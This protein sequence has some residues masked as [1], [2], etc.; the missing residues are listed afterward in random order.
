MRE[1]I[2]T[3][4]PRHIQ[5]RRPSPQSVSP[6]LSLSTRPRT[7]AIP[8]AVRAL[9]EWATFIRAGL[10]LSLAAGANPLAPLPKHST[11]MAP[12]DVERVRRR[13]AETFFGGFPI[14]QARH[15][16]HSARQ[17]LTC[18][19]LHTTLRFVD[20]ALERFAG[21]VAEAL[22]LVNNPETVSSSTTSD[23]LL[24]RAFDSAVGILDQSTRLIEQMLSAVDT[25]LLGQ[26]AGPRALHDLR[27]ALAARFRLAAADMHRAAASVGGHAILSPWEL[28]A[29]AYFRVHLHLF[30]A[31]DRNKDKLPGWNSGS[32][33]RRSSSRLSFV[34][35]GGGKEEG[36][37]PGR[38]AS[39]NRND[40]D[41]EM[42]DGSAEDRENLQTPTFDNS[43][44]DPFAVALAAAGANGGGIE[45]HGRQSSARL[46]RG[47]LRPPIDTG[48][49]R[50]KVASEGSRMLQQFPDGTL[51]AEV[52][53]SVP[54]ELLVD[55][56]LSFRGVC[57][58]LSRL[59]LLR[60][61]EPVYSDLVLDTVRDH[62]RS[63]C[64]GS[65]EEEELL[66][67]MVS[68]AKDVAAPWIGE[69]IGASLAPP[70]PE[71]LALKRE[72]AQWKNRI[73]F[74][75]ARE[76]A[77]L[78]ISEIFN[79]VV[80]FPNSLPAL[81]DLRRAMGHV[82]AVPLLV[83]TLN[84][85]IH[86]RLLHQGA[87]TK[88]ILQWYINA[89]KAMRCLDPR[90][91]VLARCG[92]GIRRYLRSRE[93]TVRCIIT[94]ILDDVEGE[95]FVA[96]EGASQMAMDEDEEEGGMGPNDEVVT[97]WADPNWAPA[98][99]EAD[100]AMLAESKHAADIMATLVSIYDTKEVFIREFQTLLADRLLGIRNYDTEREVRNLEML[101]LRFGE[102]SLSACEVMLKDLADSKRLD[103]AIQ[104]SNLRQPGLVGN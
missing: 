25:N 10:A 17:L 18:S 21:D 90:G 97:D 84:N 79:M 76:F 39:M 5:V 46:S 6:P 44:R 29:S 36:R 60:D 54:A 96:A 27:A 4:V 71:G 30:H 26:P 32:G 19:C 70:G 62:I 69:M 8:E 38:V 20:S 77:E 50:I 3:S 81:T 87:Q 88:D 14:E 66:E 33:L 41:A 40:S 7:M 95:T 80:D 94:A 52:F 16:F 15:M 61:L 86:R 47:S 43:L 65:F 55:G 85:E 78:R 75:T 73:V 102:A 31:M 24:A 93:D 98:P 11:D 92:K 74:H 42:E 104:A 83:Q 82:E 51:S 48:P 13:A 1:A 72:H 22:Q 58:T 101:K 103:V 28:A 67:K 57:A 56:L 68:W 63:Q 12:L 45:P 64:S 34:D 59:S 23:I 91:L 99:M 2:G 9:L 49:S 89:I 100:T 53:D 35:T 37:A